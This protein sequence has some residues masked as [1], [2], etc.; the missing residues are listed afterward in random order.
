MYVECETNNEQIYSIAPPKY[1]LESN[2]NN[3]IYNS[4][5]TVENTPAHINNSQPPEYIL[6]SSTNI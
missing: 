2:T 3:T 5:E 1:I 4:L 6:K